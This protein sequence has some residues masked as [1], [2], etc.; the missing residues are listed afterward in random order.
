MPPKLK[1]VSAK[2]WKWNASSQRH[3]LGLSPSAPEWTWT[4]L[5]SMPKVSGAQCV[6][7]LGGGRGRV[8]Q[9]CA[10]ISLLGYL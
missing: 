8:M 1:T 9:G 3:E 4:R 7:R 10:K 6:H 5:A 2:R